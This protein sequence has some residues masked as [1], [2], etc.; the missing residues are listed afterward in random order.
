MTVFF[1]LSKFPS[2][3]YP[4]NPKKKAAVRMSV[5]IYLYLYRRSR[6]C[7]YCF[8]QTR[9]KYTE[10]FFGAP[11]LPFLN[12]SVCGRDEQTPYLNDKSF[13]SMVFHLSIATASIYLHGDTSV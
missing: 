2:L 9:P 6:E 8:Q 5:F 1:A 3:L 13:F 7:H 10:F 12:I 4:E 11:R